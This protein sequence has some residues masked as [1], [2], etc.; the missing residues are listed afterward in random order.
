MAIVEDIKCPRCDRKYSGVR[1]RCPYC[2]AR[3]IGFG[4]YSKDGDNAKGKM[5]ISVL[6]LAVF[7]VAALIMMLTT[8]GDAVV[9]EEPEE[10]PNLEDVISLPAFEIPTPEPTPVETPTP[11]PVV[12]NA[13]IWVPRSHPVT[14]FTLKVGESIELTAVLDPPGIEAPVVWSSTNDLDD[15]VFEFEEIVGGVRVK[16]LRA[17]GAQLILTVGDIEQRCWVRGSN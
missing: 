7:T 11:E 13:Q 10:T 14:D 8:P 16:V 9:I 2:G 17:G 6:I 5:L 12:M 3:R 15:P 1:S 4:K